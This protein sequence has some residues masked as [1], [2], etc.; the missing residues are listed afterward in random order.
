MPQTEHI[1][2]SGPIEERTCG[3][4]FGADVSAGSL[5]ISLDFDGTIVVQLTDDRGGRA[6]GR[7][8]GE[9]RL[10]SVDRHTLDIVAEAEDKQP[11]HDRVTSFFPR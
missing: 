4:S 2:L 3:D 1:V 5:R 11:N 10:K 7:V 8:L 6:E 9:F